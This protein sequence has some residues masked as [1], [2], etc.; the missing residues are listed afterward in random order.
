MKKHFKKDD[1]D[2][3]RNEILFYGFFEVTRKTLTGGLLLLWKNEVYV[4]IRSLSFDHMDYILR[5]DVLRTF[6]FTSF[7]GNFD[8]NLRYES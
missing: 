7:Y 1:Y 6:K 5:C 2:R 4:N 8:K 3:I